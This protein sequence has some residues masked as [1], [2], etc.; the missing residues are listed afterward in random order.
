MNSLIIVLLFC[1]IIL[2]FPISL[3][4]FFK[5]KTQRT[6]TLVALTFFSIGCYATCH[7]LF[8][9]EF[10]IGFPI[11]YKLVKPLYFFVPPCIYLYIETILSTEKKWNHRYWLHFLPAALT[12]IDVIPWLGM[13][14][15]ARVAIVSS[16]IKDHSY[17]FKD[18]PG[19]I[20]MW[21]Y[22]ALMPIQGIGYLCY[23]VISLRLYKE[24]NSINLK[25]EPYKNYYQWSLI[26]V[27]MQGTIYICM[28]GYTAILITNFSDGI[29][30]IHA[31]YFP[32]VLMCSS[33]IFTAVYVYLNPR[34]L[35]GY[36]MKTE[37]HL[38]K[39]GKTKPPQLVTV[40][41]IANQEIGDL[42]TAIS[43]DN[44]S[45]LFS[46]STLLIYQKLLEAELAEQELYRQQGLTIRQLATQCKVPV[47]ALSFMLRHIYNKHFNDFINEYR[48][49]YVIRRLTALDWEELTF[50]GLAYEAGFSSRTTFFMAF[51]KK[52]GMSPT[53]FLQ[54]LRNNNIKNS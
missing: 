47:R 11:F 25:S 34:I 29:Y 48:I 42:S 8:L 4:L 20:P 14:S 28:T 22:Y 31:I 38:L 35:F 33:L 43:T 40:A 26:L 15:Y 13:S 36:D 16:I 5:H 49:L 2:C 7:F 46:T 27:M 1:S 23:L 45:P 3:I 24:N 12:L 10:I 51:K 44:N 18:T 6:N 52:Q 21:L 37:E 53:I 32:A 54:S 50:E 30:L 41:N 39:D 19:A 17:I 9:T